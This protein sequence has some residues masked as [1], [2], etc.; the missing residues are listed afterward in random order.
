MSTQLP[1]IETRELDALTEWEGNARQG[2]VD[3][4]KESMRTNGVFQPIIV[5]AQTGKVIAG[6]H[7][8]KAMRELH[9]EAPDSW[10]SKV[11]VIPLDVT[12]EE[13]LR[14][15][16]AD[17][18]TSDDAEWDIRA[19]VAQLDEVTAQPSGLTGT[20]FDEDD[21][22]DLRDQL[23]GDD[24]EERLNEVGDDEPYHEKW[25]LVIS[26]TSEEDQEQK[27]EKLTELG[28]EPRALNL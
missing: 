9:R 18:K 6:N 14:I 28:F 10:P 3:V 16:L 5:Q 15:H 7:R 13:A 27:F 19:L 24:A 1:D 12:D 11:S 22:N 21:L 20:G 23:Y 17:N 25:E 4:I 2:D 8:L 26:C